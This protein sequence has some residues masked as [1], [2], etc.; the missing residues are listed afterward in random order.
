MM[1]DVVGNAPD[2][3]PIGLHAFKI[4][5]M[6]IPIELTQCYTFTLP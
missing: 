2:G 6:Y 5:K 4:A 1:A 3:I